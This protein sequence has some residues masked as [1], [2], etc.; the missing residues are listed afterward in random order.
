MSISSPSV[1]GGSF[2]FIENIHFLLY[3]CQLRKN[4]NQFHYQAFKIDVQAGQVLKD[5]KRKYTWLSRMFKIFIEIQN[6]N[7]FHQTIILV[8]TYYNQPNPLSHLKLKLI[9]LFNSEV[10]Q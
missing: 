8:A 4:L 2:Q 7:N 5:S 1:N 10:K 3:H 6:K 9:I